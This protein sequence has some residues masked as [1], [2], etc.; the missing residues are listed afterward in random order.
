MK[1]EESELILSNMTRLGGR[2]P[3]TVTYQ[4]Q[5][6]NKNGKNQF[7]NPIQI[8]SVL[9]GITDARRIGSIDPFGQK[10]FPTNPN[11]IKSVISVIVWTGMNQNICY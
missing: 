7:S 1:V 8:D 6:E 9:S 4:H 5:E 2:V 3:E 11:T 10:I